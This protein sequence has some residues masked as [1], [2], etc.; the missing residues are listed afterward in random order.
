MPADIVQPLWRDAETLSL[1]M[2]L[3]I[4]DRGN[5]CL[6]GSSTRHRDGA[7]GPG[8]APGALGARP[9]PRVPL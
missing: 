5:M 7:L 8:I 9:S 6:I 3:R 1:D 4:K 2:C